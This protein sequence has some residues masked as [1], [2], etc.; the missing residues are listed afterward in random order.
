MRGNITWPQLFDY[1]FH[2]R[3]HAVYLRGIVRLHGD[4]QLIDKVGYFFMQHERNILVVDGKVGEVAVGVV[5]DVVVVVPI[6]SIAV[7]VVVGDVEVAV[8]HTV[9]VDDVIHIL[10][11]VIIINRTTTATT[12]VVI[13]R[14]IVLFSHSGDGIHD[15]VALRGI[16]VSRVGMMAIAGIGMGRRSVIRMSI[17]QLL[18]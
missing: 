10:H 6:P 15:T 3:N 14:T 16:C 5:I 7:V 1:F 11:T 18:R 9:A 13:I 4:L 17:D 12:I 2:P 8:V